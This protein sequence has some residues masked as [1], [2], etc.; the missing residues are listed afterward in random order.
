MSKGKFPGLQE[1]MEK[2][3]ALFRRAYFPIFC[4]KTQKVSIVKNDPDDDKFIECAIA[5]NAD[6]IVSGNHDLLEIEN[7]MGIKILKPKDFLRIY[8][9]S[10]RCQVALYSGDGQ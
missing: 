3:L 8:N 9:E 1:K 6:Y 4:S 5:L 7:Y 10:G 2:L